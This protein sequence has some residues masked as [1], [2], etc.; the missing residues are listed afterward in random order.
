MDM[1]KA[2]KKR[3]EVEA[4]QL[5]DKSMVD[6]IKF[7]DERVPIVADVDTGITIKTLEGDMLAEFGDYII[8]G[9]DGEFYPIKGEI[10]EKTYDVD[11]EGE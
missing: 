10:F 2:T 8:K 7:I 3:I 9:V 5:T 11:G 4:I 1:E 6:C